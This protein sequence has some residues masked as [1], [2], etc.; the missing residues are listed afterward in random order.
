MMKFKDDRPFSTPDAAEQKL[1]ELANGIEA[2]HAGRLSMGVTNKQFLDAG[3]SGD[4]FRAT[5]KA[6][7]ADGWLTLYPSGGYVTFTQAGAE[8]FA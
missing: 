1:L 4:E 7:I 3:G 6:A 5:L 2:D 8:L